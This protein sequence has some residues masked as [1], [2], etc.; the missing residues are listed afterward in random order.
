MISLFQLGYN[1]GF[2]VFKDQAS[3]RVWV[4]TGG[5]ALAKRTRRVP[6]PPKTRPQRPDN[7]EANR[8]HLAWADGKTIT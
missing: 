7:Y 8:T 6:V 2:R 1:R 5:I 4:D 3:G